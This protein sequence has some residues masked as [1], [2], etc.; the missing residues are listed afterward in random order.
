MARR[1]YGL[2]VVRNRSGNHIIV[3]ELWFLLT[4]LA[5][6]QRRKFP[7]QYMG[8]LHRAIA[9]AFFFIENNAF[10]G[11]QCKCSH[12]AIATMTLNPRQPIH[13][14]IQI[15]VTVTSPESKSKH[16]LQQVK[17]LFTRCNCN[18]DFFI[19]TNRLY[20][21]QYKCSPGATATAIFS[22]QQMGCI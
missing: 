6:K 2:L 21:I 1:P 20:L 9:T 17:G 14:D 13:C 15:A 7:S 4:L 22:S 12:D 19:A 18:C 16:F 8:Y 10:Y 11:I 3:N 5:S